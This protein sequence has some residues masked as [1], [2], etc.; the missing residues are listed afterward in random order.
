MY[1]CNIIL[2]NATSVRKKYDQTYLKKTKKKTNKQRQKNNGIL[3]QIK[4]SVLPVIN[5]TRNMSFHLDHKLIKSKW[6]F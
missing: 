2:G 5:T 6:R 4:T 3:F 1:A